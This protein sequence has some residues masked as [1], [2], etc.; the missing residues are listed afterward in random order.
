MVFDTCICT[1]NEFYE[2]FVRGVGDVF[3]RG[4]EPHRFSDQRSPKTLEALL[5]PLPHPWP[6]S[7]GMGNRGQLDRESMMSEGKRA[8]GEASVDANG[9]ED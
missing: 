4:I 2:I 3:E 8:V 1:E 7:K 6:S 5:S 9:W